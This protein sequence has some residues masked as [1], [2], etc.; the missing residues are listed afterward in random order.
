MS[1]PSKSR[2][3]RPQRLCSHLLHVIN[4]HATILFESNLDELTAKDFLGHA[5]VHTTK[6]IYTDLRSRKK[7]N[8]AKKFSSYMA[9]HYDK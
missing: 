4:P 5:D 7:K 2:L 6:L 8:E 3:A 1:L 9:R